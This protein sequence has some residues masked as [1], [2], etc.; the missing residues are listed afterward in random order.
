MK[1]RFGPVGPS[2]R[3]WKSLLKAFQFRICPL[4]GHVF[5]KKHHPQTNHIWLDSA[6]DWHL[7]LIFHPRAR[8][9]SYYSLLHNMYSKLDFLFR[10]EMITWRTSSLI[11]H[12][13]WSDHA[14][15]FYYLQ[16]SKINDN[17]LKDTVC[18]AALNDTIQ[19]V[20]CTHN[21]NHSSI[22]LE[23]LEMCPIWCAYMVKIEKGVTRSLRLNAWFGI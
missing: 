2:C 12:L 1:I 22:T 13:L 11:D 21:N 16:Q 6:T 19:N 17:L 18:M 7:D 15:K 23:S 3:G 8:K 20:L 5:R 9:Y 14:P 4:S 10:H